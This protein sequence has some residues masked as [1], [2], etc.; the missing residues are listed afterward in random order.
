MSNKLHL[1]ERIFSQPRSQGFLSFRYFYFDVYE[2]EE[3]PGFS[4]VDYA[5]LL[6]KRF[7]ARFRKIKL[8]KEIFVTWN[9]LSQGDLHHSINIDRCC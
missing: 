6:A 8:C 5:N 1:R 4:L 9:G 2:D 3:G 7:H